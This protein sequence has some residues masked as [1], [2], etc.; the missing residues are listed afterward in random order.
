MREIA[1][2]RLH[3]TTGEAPLVRFQRDEVAALAALDG[4]LLLGHRRE[5]VRRSRPIAP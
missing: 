5:L 1:D 4:R 3:G 2:R